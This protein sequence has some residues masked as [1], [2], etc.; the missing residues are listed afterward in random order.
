MTEI[1]RRPASSSEVE[2]GEVPEVAAL[3]NQLTELFNT[4]GITQRAY[5]VRISRSPSSV[6]RYFSGKKLAP[7]DFIDRLIREVGEHRNTPL[8]PAVQQHL[9]ELR[10]AALK[11]TNPDEYRLESL[12]AELVAS[13]R[14]A[15]HLAHREEALHLL[16]D[17]KEGQLQ[18][19]RSEIA[20][21]RNDWGTEQLQVARSE[22]KWEA[23]N[24]G[25]T[26]ERD[27]LVTELSELREE[28]NDALRLRE[29]AERQS[30]DLAEKVR[31][32]EEELA[33][34]VFSRTRASISLAEFK[35]RLL[36]KEF[37]QEHEA[38]RDLAEAAWS[39]ELPEVVELVEW[40]QANDQT[41]LLHVFTEEVG[42]TR[43]L[44]EVIQ[45]GFDLSV[46]PDFDRGEASLRVEY[47]H[48]VRIL[49]RVAALKRSIPD[50]A[51]IA[52]SWEEIPI[53]E[54]T[55]GGRLLAH[56]VGEREVQGDELN[57]WDGLE[58]GG[59]SE[60]DLVKAF[61]SMKPER[62]ARVISDWL[63]VG[64]PGIALAM[65]ISVIDR[66]PGRGYRDSTLCRAASELSDENYE[67]VIQMVV[68]DVPD[69][70]SAR[71][72]IIFLRDA[73]SNP[74]FVLAWL[75][76]KFATYGRVE[77][78]LWGIS[79]LEEKTVA[80]DNFELRNF[81]QQLKSW[82]ESGSS[83]NAWKFQFPRRL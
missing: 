19:L 40:L 38:F 58:A 26:S 45:L 31:L 22:A 9:R 28:L 55:L 78:L 42:R 57:L 7:L 25:L 54:G 51:Q 71:Y 20:H 1:A 35:A 8:R 73:R 11:V 49:C 76:D 33:E 77:A 10:L 37:G 2:R 75:L 30:E 61:S 23:E 16:I 15:S 63:D 17:K 46:L 5:A 65:L 41:S 83:S 36:E 13:K 52:R 12:R 18:E 59:V 53:G 64:R 56:V 27:D 74:D 79:Q 43:P 48:P 4:L 70:T 69:I 34:R 44:D 67:R 39:R 66:H 32:L 50:M 80:P 6:S 29:R 81:R 14:K 62:S 24:T 72:L 3:G 21:L 82:H 47:W 68:N 60:L